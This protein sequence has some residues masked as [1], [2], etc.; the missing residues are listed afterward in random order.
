MLFDFKY[1]DGPKRTRLKAG[2]GTTLL[3]FVLIIIV[4]WMM[5]RG[6]IASALLQYLAHLSAK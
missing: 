4:L 2:W 5:G 6:D 3:L 1:N